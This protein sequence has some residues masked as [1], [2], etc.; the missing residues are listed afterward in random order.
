M[1]TEEQIR[2]H[3]YY[4]IKQSDG[5]FQVNNGEHKYLGSNLEILLHL[6]KSIKNNLTNASN[7]LYLR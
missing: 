3:G 2:A 5:Y 6:V 1:T 7:G 4:I